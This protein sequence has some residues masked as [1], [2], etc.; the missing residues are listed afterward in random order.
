MVGIAV[1][2]HPDERPPPAPLRIV[3]WMAR[4]INF[5]FLVPSPRQDHK[6]VE[7]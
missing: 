1:A 7:S 6:L 5:F 2:I 3:L 4:A